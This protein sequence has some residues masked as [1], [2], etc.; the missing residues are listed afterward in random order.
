[1]IQQH[2]HGSPRSA[3]LPSMTRIGSTAKAATESIQRIWKT[4]LTA[5]LINVIAARYAQVAD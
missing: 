2:E 1:M 5:R 4:A 3:L